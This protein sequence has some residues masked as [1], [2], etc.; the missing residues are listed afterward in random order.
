MGLFDSL[1]GVGKLVAN[2]IGGGSGS[3]T[4][5]SGTQS[6]SGTSNTTGTTQASRREFSDGM[7]QALEMGA[8]NA[9]VGATQGADRLTEQLNR[10]KGANLG[11]KQIQ[12]DA[13]AYI[14]DTMMAADN[15]LGASLRT[16]RNQAV[17]GAG[18]S[19]G[20]NSAAALLAN[21]L[22]G[23]VSAQRTGIMASTTATAK[24]LESNIQRANA[25]A[26]STETSLLS[27]ID[28]NLQAGLA[29][30]LNALRG[31]ETYQEVNEISRTDS[32]Q[33]GS[34]SSTSKTPFNW[35]AGLGNLFKDV[36]Q[37]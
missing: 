20:G 18:G 29:T 33:A 14:R 5:T 22:E 1:L 15:T 25:D 23:D 4:T 8:A 34:T 12:F 16:N 17:A 10:V 11:G 13:D 32:R 35:T 28:S 3:K 2:A 9:L 19:T 37:D 24:E 21:R 6:Q 26:L 31:G 27:G 30:L 7:L 36:G